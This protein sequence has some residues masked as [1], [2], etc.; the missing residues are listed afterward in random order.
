MA[1]ELAI[2]FMKSL[3]FCILSFN[4]MVAEDSISPKSIYFIPKHI[5]DLLLP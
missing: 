5:L 4:T 3:G 1:Q 2:L